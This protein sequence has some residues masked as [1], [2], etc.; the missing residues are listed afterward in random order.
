MRAL[1]GDERERE[2]R[3]DYLRFQLDELDAAAL[4]PGEDDALELERVRLA[5]VDQLQGAARAAEELLYGGDDSDAARDR[6]AAAA[7]ELERAARTDPTLEPVVAR[8]SARSR[9]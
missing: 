7:R 6:V 5:A 9:R 8:S 1:G 2:A 3:I 4:Q